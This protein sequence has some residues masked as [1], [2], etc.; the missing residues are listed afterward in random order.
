MSGHKEI[1]FAGATPRYAF[2]TWLVVKNRIATGERMANWQ[3]NADTSCV[4]CKHPM[5]TRE[6]L[7]SNVLSLGKYGRNWFEVFY[8]TSSRK[9]G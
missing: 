6:H 8:Y 5:E 3:L 1:W 7:F 4:F 9:S 2:I